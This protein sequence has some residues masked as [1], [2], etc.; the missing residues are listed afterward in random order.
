[1]I[2][3]GPGPRKTGGRYEDM[4]ASNNMCLEFPTE[5]CTKGDRN[6]CKGKDYASLFKLSNTVRIVHQKGD[7][8]EGHSEPFLQGPK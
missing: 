7:L 4:D 3:M 2:L 8:T 1:M 6:T 5:L